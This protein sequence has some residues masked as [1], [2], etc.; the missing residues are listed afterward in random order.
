MR[1]AREHAH[2]G[3][4]EQLLG[5]AAAVDGDGLLRQLIGIQPLQRRQVGQQPVHLCRVLLTLQNPPPGCLHATRPHASSPA[6]ISFAPLFNMLRPGSLLRIHKVSTLQN[7]LDTE[8]DS[9]FHR[10]GKPKARGHRAYK[11]GLC[12][13][14]CGA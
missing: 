6:Q 4:F 8:T 3:A 10:G 5:R 2:V 7:C 1:R 13:Q 14:I 9:I 11:Q 12:C